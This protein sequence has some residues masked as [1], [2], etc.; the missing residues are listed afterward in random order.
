MKGGASMAEETGGDPP[1]NRS[2]AFERL[3]SNSV[4]RSSKR[5]LPK[6]VKRIEDVPVV[7]LPPEETI[8]VALSLAD[9]ALIG[10]FTGLWPS[11]KT[12]DSWVQRN[13]RPLITK[14]VA[15]YSVGKGYFLFDFE[16]KDDK[17][18]I[19]RNRPYFMGPQG[20]YLN[21]WT[22][23][24]DPEADIPK[25]VPVW[26]RLPNLPM[27]CWNPKSLQTIGNALGK[28]IDMANP[29]DQYACARLC[30]EVDLEA[31]LPEAINLTVGNWSH[32]QKLDYEQLPFKCRGCH[33]YGH[34]L[35]NCPKTP[36]NQQEKG[37]G[38]HRVN[39]SRS[40]TQVGGGSKKG[41]GSRANPPEKSQE[42]SKSTESVEARDEIAEIEDRASQEKTK[43]L[44]IVIS[45]QGRD[46]EDDIVET[47]EDESHG[48]SDEDPDS[49]EEEEEEGEIE[50]ITPRMNKT[51]R[52]ED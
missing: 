42:T 31:G 12:T 41:E 18:L 25:A 5:E 37:E 23:D 14:N 44:E 49:E 2:E 29:K 11:P 16:S 27:H 30:V 19:F 34:F 6:F 7:A 17:D 36:E 22:P 38:W 21:G 40:R 51:K 47:K 10:Q 4:N 24:F 13:W 8:R 9:R 46:N 28:Y 33:E 26:V 50:I 1:S 32:I 3:I 39:R 35:R 43:E 48:K 52:E 15:S 45:D 20:L